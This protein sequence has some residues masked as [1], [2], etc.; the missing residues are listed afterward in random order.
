ME[1]N[2]M[3]AIK[4]IQQRYGS[5]DYASWQNLRKRF[6]SFVTY[7][8]AG[9]SQLTFF[10][11][12]LGQNGTTPEIT[13][14]PKAGSFG[15]QHFWVRT[16]SCVVKIDVWNLA[17]WAGTDASSLYSDFIIGFVQAGFL[18]FKINARPWIQLPVPFLYAPPFDGRALVYS[19]GISTLTLAEG[20]PNTL[21]GLVTSAP[22]A[23]QTTDKEG[24]FMFDPPP[25]IEAEQNF[26]ITISF[27]SGLVPVIGTGVTD[28][29][30]NPLKVGVILDG[31]LYRP[32]Q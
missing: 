19:A 27:P 6:Y 32:M 12:A 24:V 13:N 4:R 5:T 8:E 1:T 29:T 31:E 26:E 25:F 16:I 11:S 17:A 20:T 15:Q 7:P 22:F 30:T 9:S 18:E 10:G 28:D 23:T 3:S 2:S 14:M 21:T